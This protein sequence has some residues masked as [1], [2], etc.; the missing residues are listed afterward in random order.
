MTVSL[1]RALEAVAFGAFI[2]LVAMLLNP[3]G[4]LIN[5]ILA[6]AAG[7]LVASGLRLALLRSL[8][9]DQRHFREPESQQQ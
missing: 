3:D 4:S 7:L 5:T 2:V 9:L 1:R 8:D 6:T